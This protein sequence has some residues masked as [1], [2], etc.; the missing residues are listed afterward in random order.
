L[1][2][3][4]R[5]GVSIDEGLDLVGRLLE[6]LAAAHASGVVHRDLKPDNVFVAK[7]GEGERVKLLD[8]GIARRATEAASLTATG[9]AI[10]TPHYMSPEQAIDSKTVDAATDVWAV[11]VMLYEVL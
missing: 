8:F 6:P 7:D 11:G 9:T 2:D 3:R 1:G 10:G 5:R 4:L